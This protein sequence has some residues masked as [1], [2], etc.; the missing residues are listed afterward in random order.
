MSYTPQDLL[1]DI[2]KPD[3]DKNYFN[4]TITD[5]EPNQMY[6][7]Q[8]AWIYADKTVGD[9]SA[10]YP[11]VTDIE[12]APKRPEFRVQDA[13]GGQNYIRLTWSGKAFDGTSYG[14]N[15]DR[16]DVYITNSTNVFGDGSQPAAF[17]RTP[18]NFLLTA[19]SGTYTITLKAVTTR[20]RI[21]AASDART[22]TVTGQAA[23]EPP[24]LATGLSATTA[25]FGLTVN[26]NGTYAG[27]TFQG[28]KAVRIFASSIDRGAS[29]T[30]GI[31]SS[32]LVGNLTIDQVTNRLNIGL[33]N[34]RVALGLGS[35]TAAYSTDVYLY[36]VTTNTLNADY[37]V[38]GVVT[39]TRIN[40][41]ALRPTKANKIDLENGVISIENLEAG[42]GQFT[43]WLRTG[44]AGG[45]RIELSGTAAF[46]PSGTTYPVLP[47]LSVYSTG[48][49]AILRADLAGNVT[50]G[51]FT[52]SDLETIEADT[53]TA[54]SDAAIAKSDATLAKSDALTALNGLETKLAIGGSII[55]NP[56][57]KQLTAINA[58]GVTVYASASNSPSAVPTSGARIIMNSSGIV[59]YNAS[60]T[61]ST[62][63]VT[64]SLSAA[65][66]SALFKGTIEAST[67]TGSTFTSTNYGVAGGT[68][69]A[70]ATSGDGGSILFNSSGTQ[71]G[72]I[73]VVSNG[74]VINGGGSSIVMTDVTAQINSPGIDL[75]LDN[76]ARLTYSGGNNSGGLGSLRNTWASTGNPTAL[77]T[78]TDGDVWLK[79]V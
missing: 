2:S 51:G 32:N 73:T 72:N 45:A 63:G 29:T 14:N 44:T 46:T 9:Y 47:G 1:K 52:P 71:R 20:G 75:Q 17:F 39:Y 10:T 68:G 79:Y 11:L 65:N 50:F 61:N 41:T 49:T 28:F 56:T 19:P 77:G 60:S 8:F 55:S 34:L 22:V 62:T 42:N 31:T 26:W 78:E 38:G 6:P 16:I 4:I 12:T 70:I 24:T 58:N 3:T 25:P 59:G 18:G 13:E 33:D 40:S 64:F 74:M 21:S 66:G 43:S 23:V 53:A 36:Y 15:L 5:L 67:I 30:T 54:K 48:N 69:V 7:V 37:S 27:A 35:N 76:T 57:T